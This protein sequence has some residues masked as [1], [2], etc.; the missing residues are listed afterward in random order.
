MS[1]ERMTIY[2]P[3]IQKYAARVVLLHAT[4]AEKLG[5]HAT[6]LKS[7][8]LLGQESMTAGS[9]AEH[10]GLS[11]AA[12]TALIDRLEAGGYVVRE[13]ETNDRR[14]VTVHA[15][16][17]KV[18]EIDRFYAGQGAR[19]SQLLS[20]YSEAEFLV[21]MDFLKQTTQILAEETIRLRD[22][23]TTARNQTAPAR[24]GNATL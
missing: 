10:T 5:I 7:L 22:T 24:G 8:R 20:Q 17:E 14:R 2:V 21:I 16:P 19:M 11:G 3:L 6:D 1:S 15:V 18:D 12:V 13:R 9:L 23:P 4:V